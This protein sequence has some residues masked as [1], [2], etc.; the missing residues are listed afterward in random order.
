MPGGDGNVQLS[1]PGREMDARIAVETCPD[2]RRVL[3]TGVAVPPPPETAE[4]TRRSLPDV[5]VVRDRTSLLVDVAGTDPQVWLRQ[6]SV[7]SEWLRDAPLTA[8][9]EAVPSDD[10]VRVGSTPPTGLVLGGGGAFVSFSNARVIGCGAVPSCDGSTMRPALTAT[11]DFWMSPYV[12]IGAS[13]TTP[14][15]VALDANESTYRFESESDARMLTVGGKVGGPVGALRLYGHGG[16][17]YTRAT[18][19]TLNTIDP[20]TITVN[21]VTTTLA[22]GT[23][24]FT[25]NTEGWAWV[26]D[27]GGEVW[28]ARA[29]AIF[30]EAGR[31]ALKGEGIEQAE[32]DLDERVTFVRF[33]ARF[34][35]GGGS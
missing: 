35:I 32:I 27:G 1:G 10:E 5:F 34:R 33:G 16:L 28:L 22:G 17:T 2:R 6:G 25:E 12:A 4:C 9:G 24:T 8:S 7:P 29:F 26:F 30:G 20:T 13:F 31:A 15:E 19:T 23:Q 14:A 18:S 21:D 3:L 11:A